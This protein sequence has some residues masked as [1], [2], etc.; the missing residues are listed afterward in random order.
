MTTKLQEGVYAL[1]EQRS[2]LIVDD[3]KDLCEMI[4]TIFTNAGFTNLTIANT[5]AQAL[6][7]WS[8]LNPDMI[9]LDVMLPD[10][11]GFTILKEVRESSRIPILMLT[12]RGEADSKFLGFENGADDYLTK[13]F[14]PKE[15][16]LRVQALMKRAYPNPN[17]IVHLAASTVD[18]DC[19]KVQCGNKTFTLTSKEL[20]LFKK[21]YENV[22]RIVTT[23]SLCQTICGDYYWEGYESTLVTHIRH[24]RQ[25]IEASPSTPQSLITT[26]DIA[27]FSRWYLEDYPVNIWKRLDGLLVVGL[28]PDKV[29][30]FYTSFN[31][32]YFVTGMYIVLA[33]F[34][35][36][37]CLIIFFFLRNIH[38]IEKAV[39]PI[40]DSI[41]SLSDGSSFHLDESGELVEIRA[42]LNR[43]GK[44][45]IKKDNTR[46]DWI[47][48]I[49][50]DIRTPLSMI[51][52]YSSEIEDNPDV[53]ET[54]HNQARIIRTYSEYLK[55]LVENLNL[56]TKLEYSMYTIGHNSI[57]PVELARQV[58]AEFINNNLSDKYELILSEFYEKNHLQII[59]DTFLLN[60]M[61]T[62]LIRNSFIHNPNG[63]HI[64]VSINQDT[65]FCIFSIEDT[66]QGVDIYTLE[67]LNK[68]GFIRN[69][70]NTEHG[71]GLKI[72]NQI[73]HLHH[74][75]IK[76][77]A[78]KP[79]GLIVQISLPR[80]FTSMPRK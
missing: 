4:E 13:P 80:D 20:L 45:L 47:R 14:L 29:T 79:H 62:N 36:N 6:H 8:T 77:S 68:N 12:A 63:C 65:N 16:L 40:L 22:G 21:L 25:K 2:I 28:S 7:L 39:S 70:D 41:H 35:A 72:V 66:G 15:L 1:M 76:F 23:G 48:G 51:L 60:R 61:L 19:A 5:G 50:H 56:T 34:L 53:S 18:L 9:I 52:G 57:N 69:P 78:N 42:E 49:S 43:A 37:I 38:Q 31:K 32:K 10:I 71:L 3:Q 33:I 67:H 17:H 11:D 73:V 55:N 54:V 44:Y 59:G 58:I 27:L 30:Q 75:K 74:G 26:T 46:A 24:L 64:T